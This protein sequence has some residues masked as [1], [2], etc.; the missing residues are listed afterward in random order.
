VARTAVLVASGDLRET[1]NRLGWPAQA[2]LE[3][4]VV[5]VF[6][7]HGVNV[8]RGHPVDAARGHGFISSQRM[9]MAVFGEID[10]DVP[11]IVAEAVWQYSHH[12]LAGLRRHRGPILTVANWSGQWPGLVGM[13]NLNAS[14]TKMG[15]PYSTVWGEDLSDAFADEAIGAWI[16]AGR[17]SHDISHVRDLSALTLPDDAVALGRRLAGELAERMAILG[18]F[19]EG[20]MGMYNAIIDDEYLNP[21]GIYKERLSQSA[22]VAAMRQVTEAEAR[23]A[24]TWL[25]RRGMQFR[26]GSD[27]ATELTVEQVLDQLRL[28]IAATRIADAFGCDAIGIQYQQGLKDMAPA[29]DLAEGLLN[30]GDRPPVLALGERRELFPG[31]PVVHFNEVDEGSAVDA[32]VTNR[33]WDALGLDPATTLHDVRWGAPYGDDYVWVFEIS[34]AVPPAHLVGG[35]AGAVSERQPPV[36]FGL[37]GGTIKG[38]S[39]PGE[40]V[41]SRV[42]LMDGRLHADLGRATIV[43]LPMAETERRWQATTPQWPIMHAVLHGVTRDQMMARHRAN[44]IQVA[45]GTDAASAD[46]ALAAKAATFDA[47]GLEVHLC[48]DVRPA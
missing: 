44:H 33:V 5:N 24:Y 17:V 32:L 21:M 3:A 2:E 8:T 1:A 25:E 30:D 4:N 27:G 39:R 40:I 42:F 14:L 43:E 22:L 34:G 46:Q 6:A 47:M 38:V 9:G 12:V 15:R 16:E 10:R 45:Y 18:V 13:L 23:G 35:Y 26:L 7:R 36:Y 20:C 19:D 28:Y 41:W 37:G 31:R 29:S 48:G 11:L